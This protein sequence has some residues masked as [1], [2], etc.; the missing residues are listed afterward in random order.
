MKLK[1]GKRYVYRN[2]EISEP[3]VETEFVGCTYLMD[4][5]T[6]YMYDDEDEA[7]G[8]KVLVTIEHENDLVAEYKEF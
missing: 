1:V 3:L 2:G 4:R 7:D 8:W 6:G 5:D